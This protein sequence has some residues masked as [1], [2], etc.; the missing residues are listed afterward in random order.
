MFQ[1]SWVELF[2]EL[3]ERVEQRNRNFKL[4]KSDKWSD[5]ILVKEVNDEPSPFLG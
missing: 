3:S 2:G 1:E 5:L 4:E